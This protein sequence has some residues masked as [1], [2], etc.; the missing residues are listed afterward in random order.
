MAGRSNLCVL[1][2]REAHKAPNRFLAFRMAQRDDDTY[3]ERL[4]RLVQHLEEIRAGVGV[5]HNAE[6]LH[7]KELRLTFPIEGNCPN[8]G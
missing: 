3:R 7:G 4:I 1:V 6:D 5:A 8:P 2:R